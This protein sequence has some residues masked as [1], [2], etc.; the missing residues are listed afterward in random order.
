MAALLKLHSGREF[1]LFNEELTNHLDN[2]DKSITNI[3]DCL[4]LNIK[5]NNIQNELQ[6][7]GNRIITH[8]NET[9]NTNN[10]TKLGIIGEQNVQ[11][12]L[13]TMNIPWKD[14][15]KEPHC[16]DIEIH[17]NKNPVLIDVKNYSKPVPTHE[18]DKLFRDCEENNIHYGILFSLKSP[19]TKK[20]SFDIEHR[21]NISIICVVV[22][23]H[24]DIKTS[25]N[26]ISTLA[27][28]NNKHK[29]Q[30]IN[31]E[32][33]QKCIQKIHDKT[34]DMTQLKTR[35]NTLTDFIDKW[36]KD[37]LNIIH[38]YEITINEILY[39]LKNECENDIL[40]TNNHDEIR[41]KF[42]YKQW[43]FA[44][45]DV[46]NLNVEKLS[47]SP[48]FNKITFQLNGIHSKLVFQTKKINIHTTVQN[49]P[50]VF[51]IENIQEWNK[52][53]TSIICM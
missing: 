11:E 22:N 30:S 35:L 33:I 40:E 12:Y 38:D 18:I 3:E 2:A 53:L 8:M 36:N 1:K 5:V 27:D 26:I 23:T 14:N 44:L 7:L 52:L 10:S 37:C 19:I 50:C 17:I 15:S 13:N 47:S 41:H 21:N 28:I 32:I 29:E 45:N 39:E 25:I 51:S 9:K 34:R 6:S 42:P 24:F 31:K 43:T 49:C 20:V 4:Q 16:A 48:E 46:L